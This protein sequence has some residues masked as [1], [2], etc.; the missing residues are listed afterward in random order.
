MDSPGLAGTGDGPSS[1]LVG[2]VGGSHSCSEIAIPARSAAALAATSACA[3]WRSASTLRSSSSSWTTHS[4]IVDRQ[5]CVNGLS[6]RRL[7]NALA[8]RS[9]D[10]LPP[11]PPTKPQCSTASP[12]SSSPNSRW[13]PPTLTAPPSCTPSPTTSASWPWPTPTW[14]RC[15]SLDRWPCSL[16][17]F[18]GRATVRRLRSRARQCKGRDM[19]RFSVGVRDRS[20]AQMRRRRNCKFAD[21]MPVKPLPARQCGL[22]AAWHRFDAGQLAAPV[23]PPASMLRISTSRPAAADCRLPAAGCCAIYISALDLGDRHTDQVWIWLLFF[24]VGP[25]HR[26][27][28]RRGRAQE[29]ER[30]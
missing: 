3:S 30:T 7:S 27:R 20:T 12:R 11:R 2:L 13:T 24:T 4:S 21:T 14:Y 15:W 23:R 28:M 5:G 16:V 19:P 8:E 22:G 10:A 18:A 6:I 29:K 25:Q 17:L 1:Q 9:G 26:P